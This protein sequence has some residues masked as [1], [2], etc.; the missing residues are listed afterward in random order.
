MPVAGKLATIPPAKPTP[1]QEGE[2]NQPMMKPPVAMVSKKN[3]STLPACCS[4]DLLA[5]I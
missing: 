1:A 4:G 5:D 2:R 3:K